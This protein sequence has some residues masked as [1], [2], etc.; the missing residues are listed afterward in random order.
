MKMEVRFGTWNVRSLNRP[1]SLK[2]ATRELA[3]HKL[4]LVGVQEFRWDKGGMGSAGNHTFLYGNGHANHHFG[5]GFS[6]HKGIRAAVT[7]AKIVSEGMLY[8]LLSGSWCAIIVLNV[9]IPY[10]NKSN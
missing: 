6:V 9:H 3:K 8:I 7:R 2:T 1:N 5:R 10:Q 4:C